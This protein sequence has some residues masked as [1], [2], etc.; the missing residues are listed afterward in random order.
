MKYVTLSLVLFFIVRFAPA[1]TI[2]Q[3]PLTGNVWETLSPD[4]MG[5]CDDK[6][7]DLLDNLQSNQTK[8]FILMKDGRIVVE[9]Y[10]GTF[11]QDSLWVWNSAG[12]TMTALLTGIAQEQGH[13]S[14]QDRTSQYLGPGWTQLSPAQEDSIR[15]IHQLTMTTGLDDGL[16]DDFCTLDTCLQYKATA[17]TRWAYHNAPYTLLTNVIEEAT[18][19][20][21][22]TFLLQQVKSKT[23]ITGSFF[24]IGYNRIYVS[25]ARS[26][27]RFALLIQN[28]GRWLNQVVLQDTAYINQMLQTSQPINK[29]Y[30]Y[31]WW[32]N[33]KSS[34]MLPGMT[35][36]FP[37]TLFS[38]APTDAVSAL[39]KD[40]QIISI[41]PS[42]GLSYI[43]MGLSTGSGTVD[44]WY[45]DTIWRYIS[46]LNCPTNIHEEADA[47]RPVVYP[48]PAVSSRHV[49]WPG[50]IF[51]ASL[52]DLTGKKV[53]ES[54][55][56]QEQKIEY[57]TF[58]LP[59]GCYLLQLQNSR[60]ERLTQKCLIGRQE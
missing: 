3:P 36:A 39:G 2:Y 33:G 26:M 1:Q 23:G 51:T 59:A 40:G 43:R 6:L 42:T 49:Y 5:W 32:L 7:N 50:Q 38:S 13:L 14:I 30:G 44:V 28:R 58:N 34:F 21:I 60:G 15:I 17:G 52:L 20:P 27:A 25:N 41:S 11:T 16:P 9:R 10:F 31:L 48:Q 46:G 54:I 18:S 47:V 45:A 4:S 55:L 22:N 56:S 37:G 19:S 12:K 35:T 24:Q 29:S 8:A 57:T 53:R